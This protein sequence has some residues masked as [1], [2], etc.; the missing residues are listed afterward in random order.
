MAPSSPLQPSSSTLLIW[1]HHCSYKHHIVR[2]RPDYHHNHPHHQRSHGFTRSQFQIAMRNGVIQDWGLVEFFDAQE[3]EQTQE[4]MNG[5]N[6]G[7]RNIRWGNMVGISITTLEGGLSGGNHRW[8]YGGNLFYNLGDRNIRWD[9]D[10][11]SF[12][13]NFTTWEGGLLGRN[14]FFYHWKKEYLVRICGWSIYGLSR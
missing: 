11:T 2:K 4:R 3:A 14:F 6:L 7:G 5:Y 8:I 1:Y 9:F 10:Y 12:S 13:G